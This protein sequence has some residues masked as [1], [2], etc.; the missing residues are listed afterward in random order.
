MFGADCVSSAAAEQRRSCLS[1]QMD[2]RWQVESS[3]GSKMPTF[4]RLLQSECMMSGLN[5]AAFAALSI[6]ICFI[7]LLVHILSPAVS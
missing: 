7:L 6:C 1:E 5:P 4:H 2:F 3:C